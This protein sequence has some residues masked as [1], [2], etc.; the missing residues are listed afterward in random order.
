MLT[1]AIIETSTPMTLDLVSPDPE[2][3]LVVTSITGLTPPEM[4]LFLGDFARDGGYYQGRRVIKRNPVFN[5]KINPDYEQDITVSAVREMLYEMFLSEGESGLKVRLKSSGRPDLY[6]IGHAEKIEAST[7]SRQTIAQVSM[8]CPDPYLKSYDAVLWQD[9]Q[10]AVSLPIDY[11]GS[12]PSGLS[13]IIEV[14]GGADGIDL[15]IGQQR[16]RLNDQFEDGDILEINTV[17]GERVVE[18]NGAPIMGLLDPSARW[19][20]LRPGDNTL[21]VAAS[22]P[23]PGGVSIIQYEYRAAWWGI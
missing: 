18:K 12:A 1:E 7:F 10:G 16:M 22:V 11:E 6:F 5:F 20:Y 9:H 4:T 15:T 17:Q 23:G 8:V 13:V 3:I 21:A 2:E 14:S 19:L